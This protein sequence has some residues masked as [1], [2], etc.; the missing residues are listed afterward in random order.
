MSASPPSKIFGISVGMDPKF[1]AGG[2]LAV[3][4]LVLLYNSR[5][6]SGP[7]TASPGTVDTH[8]APLGSYPGASRTRP[9]QRRNRGAAFDRGTLRIRPVDATR[10]DVD[11]TLRLDMLE[12]LRNVPAASAGR[13]LFEIGPAAVIPS[14]AEIAKLDQQMH[15]KT[16]PPQPPPTEM[17]AA[18]TGPPVNIPLKFYGF[19]KPAGQ[20][21]HNRG[22][23]MNG[24]NVV[25]ASEGDLI[26]HKYLVVELTPVSAKMEDVELKQ[27]QTLPVVPE[28][29]QQ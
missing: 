9:G 1:V 27:A 7:S 24:D 10:G 16:G 11:P 21:Q 12:R 8:S 28:A 25:V 29:N 26:D 2:L 23:F 22:L 17:G 15:P 5:S 18:S 19:A 6:S 13:S 14:A 3:A 4:L 20:T